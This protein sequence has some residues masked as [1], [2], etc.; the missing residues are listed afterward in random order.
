L[1]G[2]FSIN[3]K[4]TFLFFGNSKSHG[5]VERRRNPSLNRHPRTLG[6][7]GRLKATPISFRIT[8]AETPITSQD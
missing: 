7:P 2:E 8:H 5:D 1:K 4:L 3:R 6:W